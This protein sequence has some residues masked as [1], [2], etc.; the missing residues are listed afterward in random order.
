MATSVNPI[1]GDLI[2]TKSTGGDAYR[3]GWD[4]IFGKKDK[5]VEQTN[6]SKEEDQC[7]STSQQKTTNE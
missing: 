4:R 7:T 3:D 2:K 6:P 1:T 5:P